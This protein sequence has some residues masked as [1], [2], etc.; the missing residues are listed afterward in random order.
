[1][2]D[3]RRVLARAA[4]LAAEWVESA[5][6]R[7]IPARATIAEL[8]EAFGGPL[9]EEPTPELEVVER[10]ARDAEPGLTSMGSGRYFGF[11]IGG[12]LP[13]A[14]G[15]DWLVSAWDQNA[16]LLLPTPTAAVVEETAGR[17]VKELL[18]LPEGASFAFVT[19][20][21]MAHT[22]ALAVARD[23][24]L[25]R[26]GWSVGERGLQGGPTLRIVAGE[27]RHVTVD[28]ALR[29]LGI[30]AEQLR[31]VPVDD[32]GRMRAELLPGVLAE[33]RGPTIV[34]AQAGEVNTGS[35]ED[36]HAIADACEAH[37]AWMHVDGAFGLW[38]AASPRF[39]HLVAGVERADSW[40]T[41]G[42]KWLNVPYD[43]GIALCA[44]PAAHRRAMS[45]S[46]SYLVQ[47]DESEGR[48]PIS[49]TPE[50]SRRARSI[51]VYAAIQALSRS[52]LV[53]LVERCCDAATRLADGVREL[54]GSVVLNDVVLNQVLARFDEDETTTA[55][56]LALQAD[57]E[58]WT[59]GTIWQGRP[60]I[61][62]S[63]SSWRTTPRDVDRTVAALARA[64]DASAAKVGRGERDP[65][66]DVG[67]VRVPVAHSSVGASDARSAI[68]ETTAGSASVVVSPS[69]RFSATSRS[70]RRMIL[71]ERVFGSSGVKTMLAGFAIAPIFVATWPRSSSSISIEPSSPPL[72]VTYATI[73]WPVVASVRP[74]TAASATLGWS[75]SADSTSIVEMRWPETFITSSTRPSSQKSPSASMRAPSPA[76]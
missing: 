7:P 38:A 4:E 46:A 2:N 9:P 62:F 55:T 24:V 60:A 25:D 12:T 40:A 66:Q 75:T 11:V 65:I 52:G 64:L 26:A 69:G 5:P 18:H 43:C 73:A 39:R 1:V 51:P 74:Q 58:A 23:A 68:S 36:F 56:L 42:H 61:R 37:A 45:A 44:D 54:P 29:V 76:K 50:F 21:Q 57:G 34:C 17:W 49:Y 14:L 31:L 53:A 47:V 22:T 67:S 32:Q 8:R 59:S 13:A 19:G 3:E 35:F 72:S 70:S 63:V 20:C 41:D 6:E 27:K 15:A 30:G 33:S 71:P 16:G 28:R 10:L 48:E